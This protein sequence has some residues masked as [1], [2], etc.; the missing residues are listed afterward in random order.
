M[1]E[2]LFSIYGDI[3]APLT[4]P[5]FLLKKFEDQH[6]ARVRIE[7]MRWEDAWSK[8]LDFALHGGGPHISIIGA[9]W[10][11]SLQS[12]NTLR[13]FSPQEIAALG[14]TN[15]FFPS[16]WENA[17]LSPANQSWAVPFNAYTYLLLYRRDL[18]EKAGIDD[19]KAFTSPENLLATLEKLKGAGISSPIILPS[20][21][22]FLA[23]I[24]IVSSWIWGAGG[25]YIS[26]DGNQV[27]LTQD[28]ALNG[29]CDFFKLYRYLDPSD[30]GLTQTECQRRFA[31]GRAA[32]LIA[33]SNSRD[34]LRAG[35]QESVLQNLGVVAL[36]GVPWIAGANIVIWREAQF[37]YHIEQL[38]LALTKYLTSTDSQ[39]ICTEAMDT[40]PVKSDAFDLV[41]LHHPVFKPAIRQSLETG[42]TYIPVSLW[43]RMLNQ[44]RP[45]LD[46]ITEDLL[47]NPSA[48][49]RTVIV[50][51]LEPLSRRFG[52]LLSSY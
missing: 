46:L 23:R 5:D 35:A 43:T 6:H 3:L 9:I 34:I 14:G 10:T 25:D 40:I 27:L 4:N 49:P 51:H 17:L 44:L 29:L 16:T 22:A 42:R 1:N 41:S 47:E 45:T 26:R 18:L 7:P 36:P 12:M 52:V 2:I 33:G 37:N 13:P 32:V 50:N 38:A 11:G 24:N 39:V 21:E 30:Y 28:E 20:G 15:A 8:L 19:S 31:A 48:D